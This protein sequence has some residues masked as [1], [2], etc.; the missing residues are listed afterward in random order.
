V[1]VLDPHVLF[2]KCIRDIWDAGKRGICTGG[3]HT[4]ELLSSVL[5]GIT[6]IDA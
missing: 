5:L 3:V 1:S 2:C 6:G 4:L